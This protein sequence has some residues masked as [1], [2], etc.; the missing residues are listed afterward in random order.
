MDYVRSRETEKQKSKEGSWYIFTADFSLPFY[1]YIY[2]LRTHNYELFSSAA[3]YLPVRPY[4]DRPS[5]A[6]R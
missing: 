4:A 6:D 1:F 5:T 3:I 2:E